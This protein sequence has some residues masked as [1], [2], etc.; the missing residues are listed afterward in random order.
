LETGKAKV[1]LLC[2]GIALH[3]TVWFY[4]PESLPHFAIP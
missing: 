2:V 1:N 4:T 3:F